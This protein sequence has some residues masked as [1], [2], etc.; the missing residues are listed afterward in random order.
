ML[1]LEEATLR[2]LG[3]IRKRSAKTV[4][5]EEALGFVLAEDIVAPFDMPPFNKSAM[6]GYAVSSTDI[7][8]PPVR[9]RCTGEVPAG[10]YS[11]F[12]IKKGE[13]VKIMT[14]SPIPEGADS[15]VMVE[16]TKSVSSRQSAVGSRQSAVRRG[17]RRVVDY[18]QIEVSKRVKEG[19]N[20]CFRGEE[21]KK[22]ALVLQKGTLIRA[23]E[24]SVAASLG[25]ARIKVYEAPKIA[26]LTTGSEIVEPGRR[27]G[28]GKIYN[29]NA[30]LIRSLLSSMNLKGEYLGIARDDEKHLT[31]RIKAGLKYEVL[32]ISG[33]VSQGDYDLVPRILKKCQVR[34]VFHKVSIKPGKPFL[35]GVRGRTLVFGVPGNPVS[36]Y[37]SFLVL[38][39]PALNKM[40]GKDAS[41]SICKGILMSDFHGRGGRKRFLPVS[42]RMRGNIREVFPVTTYHGSADMAALVRADS[43][44]I[45][46]RELL[47]LKKGSEVDILAFSE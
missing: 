38:I 46:E 19:E 45:V 22:G 32:I 25:K 9:L 40:M 41:C 13:C 6:D 8:S 21:I 20:V 47:S 2:I 31:L 34:E 5:L 33:G 24:V 10:S 37:L 18:E 7:D 12:A 42:T 17:G 27:V 14:G 36:T 44:M 15:V 23:V 16:V 1:E 11:K 30:H 26:V 3:R 29:S 28:Y 4:A 35:F 43:F 39:R